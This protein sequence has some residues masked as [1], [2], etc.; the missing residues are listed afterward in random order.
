MVFY[1]ILYP[2]SNLN[3]NFFK[4]QI[5]DKNDIEKE[6]KWNKIYNTF[7]LHLY[8]NTL[9]NDGYFKYTGDPYKGFDPNASS[10]LKKS[11]MK[12]NNIIGLPLLLLTDNKSNFHNIS[13]NIYTFGICYAMSENIKTNVMH[14]VKFG[15]HS[16]SMFLKDN[17]ISGE[18]KLKHILYCI[19][20]QIEELNYKLFLEIVLDTDIT[21]LWIK[22]DDFKFDIYELLKN[23]DFSNPKLSEDIYTS[24]ENLLNDYDEI[25]KFKSLEEVNEILNS[26]KNKFYNNLPFI[27]E[28]ISLPSLNYILFIGY[29]LYD[30]DTLEFYNKKWMLSIFESSLLTPEVLNIIPYQQKTRK[31][32]SSKEDY[33]R[34][35]DSASITKNSLLLA[36]KPDK[37][38]EYILIDEN[39]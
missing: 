31:T 26:K 38:K 19:L 5:Y 8:S 28:I 1:K 12:I 4:N 32:F 30:L 22:D 29:I 17:S 25:F 6:N 24:L 3:K 33:P 10:K 27:Y 13:R 11:L 35:C 39:E 2:I 7:N 15:F 18:M 16:L 9:H 23:I 14:Y 21:D 37:I 36:K 34:I 20:D